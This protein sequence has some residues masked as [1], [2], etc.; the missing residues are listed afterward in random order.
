MG[1]NIGNIITR[2][3]GVRPYTPNDTVDHF[4]HSLFKNESPEEPETIYNYGVPIYTNE[5]RTVGGRG[6]NINKKKTKKQRTKTKKPK[7]QKNREQ[8]PKTK[9]NN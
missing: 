5:P 1:F 6:N 8:K 7:K 4:L 9:K 3:E 2:V